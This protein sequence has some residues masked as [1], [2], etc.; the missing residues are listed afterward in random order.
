M[1]PRVAHTDTGAVKLDHIPAYGLPDHGWTYGSGLDGIALRVPT[2]TDAP[3]VRVHV[4]D[5]II[6]IKPDR[7]ECCASRQYERSL[8][9]PVPRRW[10]HRWPLPPGYAAA[11]TH[12]LPG[13]D[14][15]W[16]QHSPG[17]RGCDGRLHPG[18][19]PPLEVLPTNTNVSPTHAYHL[20][21]SACRKGLTI[22]LASPERLCAVAHS[23]NTLILGRGHPCG[24]GSCGTDCSVLT[25]GT[26]TAATTGPL[27]GL[28]GRQAV[29]R[30]GDALGASQIILF[31][32][33][34]K[35]AD[36][37]AYYDQLV[38]EALHGKATALSHTLDGS[39]SGEEPSDEIHLFFRDTRPEDFIYCG[40]LTMVSADLTHPNGSSNSGW[41]RTTPRGQEDPRTHR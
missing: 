5:R 31:V 20:P 32:T 15:A 14:C 10:E 28:K 9:H 11:I 39:R 41:I 24:G 34:H 19:D 22:S 37:T 30:R 8:D 21:L 25:I 33:Q 18:G 36:M 7:C 3:A 35:T 23:G 4:D 13:P 1:R 17:A 12:R 29:P 6:V 40:E 2:T 38:G 16:P 27:W 26:R